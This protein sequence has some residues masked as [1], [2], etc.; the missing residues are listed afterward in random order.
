MKAAMKAVATGVMAIALA[1][2]GG[3]EDAVGIKDSLIVAQGADAKTLDPHATNDNSSSRVMTQIYSTLVEVDGNMD[4]VPGL[5]ESWTH[6][7]NLTTEFNLR[8]GVKFHNG[9][10]LKASDV[11]FTVERMIDS[12]TVSHIIGAVESVEVIDNYTVHLKTKEPFGPLLHH[13]AHSASSILNEKAVAEGGSSYGQNPV[14]TGPYSF[15]NWAVG[16]RIDLTSF[17]NYYGGKQPITNVTFRNIVE[18]TNRAIALET[19]EADISYDIDPIDES[20]IAG[21]SGLDLI[22]V[23]SLATAYFGMNVTKAPFDQ[24][25][26]RQA[27][28]YAINSKD[29]V[30][31]VVLGSGSPANSPIGP[32]VFGYNPDAKLYDQNI[33]KAKALMAEAGITKPVKT[34]IWTNDNPVRVQIAQ[35]LQA[36]LREIG[37]DMSIEVVEWGAF[38]DGTSR[39]EHDSFILGWTTVTGD[40]DYGLYALFHSSTHGGAGNRSFYSNPEIDKLLDDA[41]SSTDVTER[42]ALYADI[43][44]RL[45]QELPT[46]SIYNQFYNAGLKNNIKGFE[47]SPAGHHKIR[48]VHF[49]G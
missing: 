8:K 5:A 42:R 2:C 20:T 11:K 7:D 46:I 33:E 25:K 40:A 12:A 26:V 4:I 31:A 13:L 10:E 15:S 41:R 36:Q 19:G 38:L 6:I 28:A 1:A 45:Q 39:G 24:Q 3:P 29:I 47:L 32:Q 43:Q 49:E 9:E 48:G 18:G 23:E 17:D 14:G 27:V 22:A 37:I 35:V 34:T 44:V 30:D 21:K 16:D